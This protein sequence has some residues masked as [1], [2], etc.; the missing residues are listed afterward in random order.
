MKRGLT[1][2]ERIRLAVLCLCMIP[3]M[4]LLLRDAGAYQAG[5]LLLPALYG[6]DV[7]SVLAAIHASRILY[8][9]TNG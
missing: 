9:P 8:L 1:Y 5:G 3:L 4:A 7:F 2:L 6:T